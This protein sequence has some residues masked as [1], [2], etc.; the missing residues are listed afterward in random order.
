M[1]PRMASEKVKTFT[2]ENFEGEVLNSA[3]PVLVDFWAEWCMP[4]RNLSPI[5]DS[6]AEELAGKATVGKVDVDANKAVP[7]RYEVTAIP[8][9]IIFKGGKVVK[10]FVGFKKKE[11]LVA[12]LTE[13][14]A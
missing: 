10:K 13:A 6:V 4:C 5:V 11:D 8:T 3:N 9:I 2:D 14:A 12:A 1:E 7:M